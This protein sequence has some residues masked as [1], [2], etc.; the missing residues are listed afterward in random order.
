MKFNSNEIK[1]IIATAKKLVREVKTANNRVLSIKDEIRS[2]A[3]RRADD[4]SNKN[5]VG[6]ISD[7]L[8]EDLRYEQERL[9]EADCALAEF[10]LLN[11][12]AERWIERGWIILAQ[13]LLEENKY[14]EAEELAK[15]LYSQGRKSEAL[16]V[17]KGLSKKGAPS[18]R[19]AKLLSH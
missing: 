7:Y 2:A 17:S 14:S 1:T 10:E 16:S 6:E 3:N 15:D 9:C 8:I 5:V 12:P 19:L 11:G 4:I 13:A 18:E